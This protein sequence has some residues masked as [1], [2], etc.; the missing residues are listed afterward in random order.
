MKK[1][2]Y[3]TVK[4]RL[5]NKDCERQIVN[6][7][8]SKKDIENIVKGR[9]WKVD[10]KIDWEWKIERESLQRCESH[11]W[12][13]SPFFAQSKK[14]TRYRMTD[15]R[16]DASTDRDIWTHLKRKQE[17]IRLGSFPD[18]GGVKCSGNDL[19]E[20]TSFV[21]QTFEKIIL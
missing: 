12:P 4:E 20:S 5:Q 17:W 14:K 10:W 11:F 16:T 19:M 21:I 3:K 15:R 2:L 8:F 9:L 18:L 13:F 7:R 6:K 1:R